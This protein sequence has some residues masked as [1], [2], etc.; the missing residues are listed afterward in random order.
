LFYFGFNNRVIEA[1]IKQN[2]KWIDIEDNKEYKVLTNAFIALKGGDGYYHF[3][4]YATNPQ[5]TYATF[6]SIMAEELNEKKELTPKEI[7]GRIKIIRE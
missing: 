5:N 2:G 6:Y 1:K 3:K 7:D 4:K